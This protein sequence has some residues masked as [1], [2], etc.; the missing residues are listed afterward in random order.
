MAIRKK[1]KYSGIFYR[2]AQRIGYKG[3]ERIYYVVYKKGGK[4]IEAKVGRQYADDMTPA[5]AARLRSDYIEGKALPASQKR[6]ESRWTLS[7]LWES[8]KNHKKNELKSFRDDLYRYKKH[9]DPVLG[10]KLVDDLCTLD[11]ERLKRNLSKELA[12]ATVKQVLALIK[13]MVRF[14][15]GL[16]YF[17]MPDPGKLSIKMP[18]INNETTEDLTSEQLKNLFKVL[19]EHKDKQIANLMKLALFLGMRRSELFRLQ[20]K[21]IDFD[22]GF[23][24]LVDPKGGKDQKIPLNDA[25]RNVL[26]SHERTT[27]PYVFPGRGGH[28][29]KDCKHAV[30]IIKEKAGLPDDFRPLHG[31]RH[32]FASALASSGKVDM[33]TLQKLLTHK[34]ASMTQRYAHLRD[35]ALKEAAEVA[36]DIFR[37]EGIKWTKI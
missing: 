30:A 31:L 7:A 34:N 18:E 4:T 9:I 2:E 1:T 8:F 13:R 15:T 6:K 24:L 21:H 14:G 19:D 20:W 36:S 22:R 28:Q 33:Y 5:R 35:E 12:P 23:V 32:V 26:L 3:L 11:I 37:N 10:N 17:K 16:G 27:S 25:A 29:R